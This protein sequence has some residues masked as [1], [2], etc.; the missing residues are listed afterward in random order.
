[1]CL[2]SAHSRAVNVTDVAMFS[3]HWPSTQPCLL[4]TVPPPPP[5]P[6][7]RKKTEGTESHSKRMG[8]LDLSGSKTHR[9]KS[10]LPWSAECCR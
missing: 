7:N 2:D 9:S 4:D 10:Y 5:T 8:D 1:M 3:S 6:G